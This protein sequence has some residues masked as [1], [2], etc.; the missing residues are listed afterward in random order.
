MAKLQCGLWD[1]VI[2]GYSKVSC[3]YGWHYCWKAL[4]GCEIVLLEWLWKQV[5]FL[6]GWVGGGVPCL[7]IIKVALHVIGVTVVGETM[8]LHYRS[9]WCSI[10]GEEDVCLGHLSHP[11][12]LERPT[13]EVRF[14]NTL[15]NLT[16]DKF[17]DKSILLAWWRAYQWIS[18][19]SL[20]YQN[21]WLCD[22]SGKPHWGDWGNKI[23]SKQS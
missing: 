9:L 23:V 14:K 3:W 8:G 22:S 11:G 7:D 5:S 15:F 6:L 1:S 4:L 12:N 20:S 17:L 2:K 16:D 18:G 13:C 21:E 10:N 19:V